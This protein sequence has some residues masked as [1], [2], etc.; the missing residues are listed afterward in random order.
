LLG[1][2]PRPNA[3]TGF[4]YIRFAGV[5]A[6]LGGTGFSLLK[7]PTT[8]LN[9]IAISASRLLSELDRLLNKVHDLL[10]TVFEH[11]PHGVRVGHCSARKR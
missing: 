8:A 9:G 2:L 7:V 1:V 4:Q 11:K 6:F 5:P 10:G 3:E